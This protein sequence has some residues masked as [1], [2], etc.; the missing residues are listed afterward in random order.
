MA[1]EIKKD[2][3]LKINGKIYRVLNVMITDELNENGKE[4][5][6]WTVIIGGVGNYEEMKKRGSMG[7]DVLLQKI[8]NKE[9]EIIN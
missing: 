8:D 7:L 9:V 3:K 1:T 4:Y 5:E 6:R 2:M